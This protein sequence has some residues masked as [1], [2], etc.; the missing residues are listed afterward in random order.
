MFNKKTMVLYCGG[1]SSLAPNAPA[2]PG[3]GGGGGGGGGPPHPETGGDGGGSGPGPSLPLRAGHLW[4]PQGFF[5]EG[6]RSLMGGGS[7]AGAPLSLIGPL[8]GAPRAAIGCGAE[9]PQ[10]RLPRL[11]R[12]RARRLRAG[13]GR[14]RGRRRRRRRKAG[15]RRRRR[16]RKRI[17]IRRKGG[18]FLPSSSPSSSLLLFP[19]KRSLRPARPSTPCRTR[20]RKKGRRTRRR[21]RRRCRLLLL[22]GR[23]HGGRGPPAPLH[24]GGGGPL[25]ARGS[26]PRRQRRRRRSGGGVPKFSLQ[27]LLGRLG[28]TPQGEAE[29]AGA[30]RALETLRRV[31][32]GIL[33]KHQLAFQGMLRKMEI[34]KEEDL[35]TMSEVATEV[36]RDGIINWG[37]IVTLIS[38]GAFVAKHLKSIN[39]ESSI[40]TLTE[41]ITDVLVT[42]KREWLVSHNAWEGFVKFFHVEDIEGGIRSVL[43]TFAGVAGLGAGLAF[44]IR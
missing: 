16:R 42:D 37:R 31:G 44:M 13:F 30:T 22:L 26:R 27:G 19:P 17:G 15:R 29:A 11:A 9:T 39:L 25:P 43:M 20:R 38:F 10:A 1:A 18:G 32:D 34:K 40:N 12:A 36:F 21:R 28:T 14:R 7:R 3:A 8:E 41:I 33:E 24:P 23:G 2:S 6:G 5:H 35:K 4:G